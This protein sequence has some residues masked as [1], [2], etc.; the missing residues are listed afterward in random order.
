[1]ITWYVNNIRKYNDFISLKNV[2]SDLYI[3]IERSIAIL[4]LL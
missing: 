1:M 3:E 2:V 4:I